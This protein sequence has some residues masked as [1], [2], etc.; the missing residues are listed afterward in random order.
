M[1]TAIDWAGK[2]EP[3]RS[4]GPSLKREVEAICSG[5]PVLYEWGN[6]LRRLRQLRGWTQGEVA[7]KA[8]LNQNTVSAA[9]RGQATAKTLRQVQQALEGDE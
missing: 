2:P 6:R 1:K 3:W 5:A 4:I 8:G 7:A 9:E